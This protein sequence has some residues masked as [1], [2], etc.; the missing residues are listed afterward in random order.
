MRNVKRLLKAASLGLLSA[1]LA[2]S[3]FGGSSVKAGDDDEIRYPASEIFALLLKERG[4][5]E[6]VVFSPYSVQHILSVIARSTTNEKLKDEIRPYIGTEVEKT[7][8]RHTRTGERILVNSASGIAIR[9]GAEGVKAVSY[10]SGALAEK[11]ALQE[12]VLG[13]V[14][15][16]KAPRGDLTFLTA[17]RFFAEWE[18]KF[19]ESLTEKRQFTLEN[20]D[21]VMATTM[22]GRIKK[23]SGRITEDYELAALPGTDRAT[24]YFLKPLRG[25]SLDAKDLERLIDEMRSQ[26][27]GVFRDLDLEVP[28]IELKSEMDL[29]PLFRSMGI[30]TFFD[31]KLAFDKI[32]EKGPSGEDRC[33]TL[34]TATQ[35]ATID[36][37]EKYAEA[38][39]VT[40][41]GFMLT[42][43]AMPSQP[44]LVKIDSPYYIVI[45]DTDITGAEHTV[46]MCFV[47]D[48]R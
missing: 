21:K 33:F 16:D 4:A 36:I 25:A 13:S 6:N 29:K 46:F 19:D 10:P 8:L 45:R 12:E 42:S 35:T 26:G 20:G 2:F 15:D 27:Q 7:Q 28:K 18:E 22:K 23:A 43:A 14:I 41:A 37:D 32:V 9:D 39:A 34:D 1:I 44:H 40:Q 48:P 38:K 31:G 24:V 3:A 47:A 11:K 30:E 17:A 5:G